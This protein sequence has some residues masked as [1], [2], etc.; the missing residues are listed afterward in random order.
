M[1]DQEK[2]QQATEH[3]RQEFRKRGEVAKSSELISVAVLFAGILIL[4]ILSTYII[5][6]YQDIQFYF[7]NHLNY[8]F[9]TSNKG[10]LG[11]IVFLG[12]FKILLPIF[13]TLMII[14]V[15]ANVA[16]TG[17]LL[18]T[19][20]LKVDFGRI[21]PLKKIKQIFFSKDAFFELI[22]SIIKILV[23]GFIAF[24]TTKSFVN[25]ILSSQERQIDDILHITGLVIFK[26]LINIMALLLVLGFADFMYQKFKMEERMKMTHQEIKDEYKQLEGDPFIK[27][28]RKQK[29]REMSMN[30]MMQ[31]VPNA[32]VV[33]ANPTHFAVAL[34][35]DKKND[36]AP[37]VVA[38]G[39]DLIAQKIK[40]IAK[41]NDV[42][43]VENKPL[44]RNLYWNLDV[45]D[46]I[47]ASLFK[48]VAELFA[49][50]YQLDKKRN[51]AWVKW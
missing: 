47:P 43:I 50:I 16:Q 9:N 2:T 14:G 25:L 35:Y 22:K 6:S 33:V 49:Y 27:G 39:A 1:A 40:S 37:I 42:P 38:K 4:T 44:A 12:I 15:V 13:L 32:D 18:T 51:K 48:A 23:I 17:L 26:L 31:A 34:R 7:F 36:D 5:E 45:G 24:S 30:R 10:N 21:N 8:D 28:K 3:Q 11:D 46:S 20:P 29:Q 41:E 19:E